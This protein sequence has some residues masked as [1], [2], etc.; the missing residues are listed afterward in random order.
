[1]CGDTLIAGMEPRAFLISLLIRAGFM[2]KLP[3]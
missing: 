1:M 2:T 3:E